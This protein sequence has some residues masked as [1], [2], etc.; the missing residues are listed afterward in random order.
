MT[1]E[2][3]T[4]EPIIKEVSKAKKYSFKKTALPPKAN[5]E[6]KP[7]KKKTLPM[8]DMKAVEEAMKVESTHPFLRS[9]V[10]FAF[11]H[12]TE[13]DPDTKKKF[14]YYYVEVWTRKTE[15][16]PEQNYAKFNIKRVG[17]T[18]D[19]IRNLKKWMLRQPKKLYN[20]LR[21]FAVIDQHKDANAK[22]FKDFAHSVGKRF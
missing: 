4:Q 8:V 7:F 17:K 10:D 3:K 5:G 15:E 19:T 12:N 20:Q 18:E 9:T 21:D 22:F 16:Q 13:E 14:D 1:E 6:K 2:V 11:V